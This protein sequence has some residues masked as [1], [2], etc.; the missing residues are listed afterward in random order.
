MLPVSGCAATAQIFCDRCVTC[1]TSPR[2]RVADLP[3]ASFVALGGDLE[4]G[5]FNATVS[6]GS[7]ALS[8]DARSLTSRTDGHDQPGAPRDPLGGPAGRPAAPDRGHPDRRMPGQAGPGAAL[9]LSGR[10]PGP[11]PAVPAPAPP[12]AGHGHVRVRD[13]PRARAAGDRCSR[14]EPAAGRRCS[15]PARRPGP[16]SRPPR[17][18]WCAW[19]PWPNSGAGAPTWAAAASATSVPS[20]PGGGQS[21]GPRC[22]PGRR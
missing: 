21:P 20:R 19:P 12:P 10:Q 18:S 1:G 7:P 15:R 13:V 17:S 5:C 22:S 14:W 9:R 8:R 16:G 6:L 4:R 3:M 2:G 11:H